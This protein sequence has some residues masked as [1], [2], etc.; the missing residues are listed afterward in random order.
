MLLAWAGNSGSGREHGRALPPVFTIAVLLL[1]ATLIHL[2]RFHHDL[3]GRFWLVVYV[4][5]VPLLIYLIWAQPKGS[6]RE[7]PAGA[8]LAGWLRAA[9]GVQAAAL[10]VFGVLLFAAPVGLH[11]I[12]PW[13]LTPLT[14]R[15]IG[16]FLCG[17]GVAAA[18]ALRENALDRLYGS[19]LAWAALGAL[20]LL[21]VAIHGRRSHRER[22]GHGALRR[23]LR[24]G[25]RAGGLRGA[26]E[27]ER[28]RSDVAAGPAPVEA[29]ADLGLDRGRVLVAVQGLAALRAMGHVGATRKGE[30]AL[31]A[32]RATDQRHFVPSFPAVS[33]AGFSGH[34]VDGL[35][36]ISGIRVAV[37]LSRPAHQ[38]PR[39]D[40]GRHRP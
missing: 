2:D 29:L 37:R 5:V 26:L 25:A 24:L 32:A 11:S 12:W 23:L 15:A 31:A 16:A 9:L 35:Y 40:P 33:V 30:A 3:Y 20:E 28:G 1:V 21:A 4:I 34:P 14:G 38:A 18:F 6:G 36:L 19:A 10:L 39:R 7:R 8:P 22:S 27:A 13:P 17:F